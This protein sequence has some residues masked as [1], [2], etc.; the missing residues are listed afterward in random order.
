M[1]RPERV[2]HPAPDPGR[3]RTQKLKRVE[4]SQ[5]DLARHRRVEAEARLR[6]KA[7]QAGLRSALAGFAAA[8]Q[9]V[10]DLQRKAALTER[11]LARAT[12]ET[13]HRSQRLRENQTTLARQRAE[14]GR[15][16]D[17]LVAELNQANTAVADS[18]KT[19]V[20]AISAAA[21]GCSRAK[22]G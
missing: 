16:R 7:A 6:V 9:A 15:D 13:E 20:D 19:A 21:K 3:A 5:R 1:V 2:A 18:E 14:C 22:M 11:E 4:L 10:A 8:K 12:R 17:A